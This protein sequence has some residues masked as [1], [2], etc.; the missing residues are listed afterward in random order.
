MAMGRFTKQIWQLPRV[1]LKQVASDILR[2]AFLL[3]R[4]RRLAQKGFVLP[5][6]VLLTIMVALTVTAL[7]YRTYV[8][9]E[10]AIGQREQQVIV[11][12]AT[13]AI[14]RAKAKIEFLFRK[15]GRLPAGLPSSDILYDLMSTK[16]GT[17]N[18]VGYTGRVSPID[19][20]NPTYDP[21][22]L[23]DETRLDINGDGVLDNAWKFD[24]ED[25]SQPDSQG[26]TIVYSI[27]V[28]DEVKL[29]EKTPPGTSI[30][31]PRLYVDADRSLKESVGTNKAKSLITRTGP[32]ATAQATPSCQG[33]LSEGGWQVVTQGN[34]SQLQKNFQITAFVANDSDVNQTFE[35]LEFQQSR[36]AARGNKWGAWFRYD[37]DIY[38][39]T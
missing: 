1:A 29:A 8:R 24:S 21:Y 16:L 20:N 28:D 3:N 4:P 34:S 11:N 35:T 17:A 22:T 5:T 14:D 30:A 13:P 37:L 12:A 26:K 38:A 33:S 9:S 25:K 23:P 19:G 7:I 39:G 10:Q 31:L 27:L 32:L 6:T 15:D 36:Q 18:F 2:L